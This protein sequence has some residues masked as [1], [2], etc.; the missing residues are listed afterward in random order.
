[1]PFRSAASAASRFLAAAITAGT[2][3]KLIE[4]ALTAPDS[5]VCFA[6]DGIVS[7]TPLDVFVPPGTWYDYWTGERLSGI[8]TRKTTPTLSDLSVLVRGGAIVPQQAV[9][10]STSETPKGPLELRVYPGSDCH[11][12]LYMDDGNTFNYAH[13]EFLRLALSCQEASGSVQVTTAPAEEF[14]TPGLAQRDTSE[15]LD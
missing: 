9:V 7:T 4:A 10:Q 3:L 14:P 6:T 2:R 11:G 15:S 8:D 12:S 1:M 13:G 5:I